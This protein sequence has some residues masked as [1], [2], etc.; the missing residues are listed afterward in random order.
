MAQE[1]LVRPPIMQAEFPLWMAVELTGVGT[2]E[3]KL[4]TAEGDFAPQ[5]VHCP[6]ACSTVFVRH[7]AQAS[8]T[9][10]VHL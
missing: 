2:G 3:R 10:T 8:H 1:K 6:F 4:P 5:T 9:P 7:D